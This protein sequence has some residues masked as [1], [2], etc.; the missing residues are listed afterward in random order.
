MS[1]IAICGDALSHQLGLP[2][3]ALMGWSV[4]NQ[5]LDI[6]VQLA[7]GIVYLPDADKRTEAMQYASLIATRLWCRY[8]E[9]PEEDPEQLTLE[10]IRSLT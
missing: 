1:G 6:L 4:S 10:Q 3:V 5:Q 7:K 8:P 2:A 9:M